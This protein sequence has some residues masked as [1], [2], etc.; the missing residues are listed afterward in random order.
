[1]RVLYIIY[2]ESKTTVEMNDLGIPDSAAAVQRLPGRS[3]RRIRLRGRKQRKLEPETTSY[4][5]G[6]WS[7]KSTIYNLVF[8][9]AWLG[10]VGSSDPNSKRCQ[11]EQAIKI[12]FVDRSQ[13]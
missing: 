11:S 9:V 8:L 12:K 4:R 13:L 10:V 2:F 3:G 1:M 5:G 6:P 7:F